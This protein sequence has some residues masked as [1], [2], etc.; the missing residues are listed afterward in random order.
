MNIYKISPENIK[1]EKQKIGVKIIPFVLAVTT[2][3]IIAQ[4]LTAPEDDGSPLLLKFI[5]VPIV[6]VFVGFTMYTVFKKQVVALESYELVIDDDTITRYQDNVSTVSIQK[7]E[8]SKLLETRKGFITI[9]SEGNPSK[10]IHIPPTITGFDEIKQTLLNTFGT[11]EQYSNKK[12]TIAF[13]IIGLVATIIAFIAMDK[14][15]LL[16]SGIISLSYFIWIF[17]YIQ[18]SALID[19]KIKRKMIF[20]IFPAFSVLLKIFLVLTSSAEL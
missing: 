8:I 18:R 2:V 1:L 6:I 3:A 4:F 5:G 15:I 14:M 7:D 10:V 12:L 9:Q 16:P 13:S 17:A 19:K 20:M 11:F